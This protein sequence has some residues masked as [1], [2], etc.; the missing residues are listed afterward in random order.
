MNLNKFIFLKMIIFFC[1]FL[2][3][4]SCGNYKNDSTQLEIAPFDLEKRDTTPSF[5]GHWEIYESVYEGKV[6]LDKFDKSRMFEGHCKLRAERI[7]TLTKSDSLVI[8]KRMETILANLDKYYF[9][10]Y[11][12][13]NVKAG[14]FYFKDGALIKYEAEGYYIVDWEL[15]RMMIEM[16]ALNHAVTPG[17]SYVWAVYKNQ[18]RLYPHHFQHDSTYNTFYLK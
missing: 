6:M 14:M 2:C 17:D 4:T 3:V 11:T 15:N 16:P 8:L 9:D 5:L 13:E 10:F 1:S 12:N 7:G 18:L